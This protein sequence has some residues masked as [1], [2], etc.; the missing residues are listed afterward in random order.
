MGA[1]LDELQVEEI[2]DSGFFS[3][4]E[5]AFPFRKFPGVDVIL[6]PEMRS[7]GEVMG[8][9]RSLPVALA[10]AQI[11]VGNDL[12][13]K[14]NVFLSVRETDKTHCVEIARELVSMGFTV[15]TTV[16]THEFL[17]KHGVETQ[18]VRK[19]SEGA[20]PNILDK[21]GSGEIQVIFNTPTRK[22]A[23]T[24]EGRIRAMAVSA[25][26]PMITTITGTRAAVQAIKALRGG[27]W[28]VAALQDYFPKLAR[29]K[30]ELADLAQ[31]VGQAE[32]LTH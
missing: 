28:S 13:V 1:S 17:G 31:G 2:P 30:A 3:V 5:P 10:K 32:L 12:P 22:G 23:H 7:T 6:G 29:P 20:R 4:K 8:I 26:V 21:I 14:G 27:T 9:H 19:I 18:L 24:D 11:A 15:I 16:G 25:G